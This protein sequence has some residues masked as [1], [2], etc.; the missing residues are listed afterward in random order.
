MTEATETQNA[1]KSKT[2]YEEVTMEDGRKVQFAG[3]LGEKGARRQLKEAIFDSDG[4]WI[5]SQFDFRN[6]KT[7]TFA[8]PS[9][10]VKI[11]SGGATGGRFLLQQL[12]AHGSLQKIGDETAGVTSI[13]DMVLAVE[14]TIDLLNKGEWGAEREG[15]G[16][17]AG[18]SILMKALVEHTGKT[19]DAIKTFLK[20]KT[21]AQKDAM[22]NDKRLK[23]IVDRLEAEEAAKA[24]HV[25]T[26]ALFGELDGAAA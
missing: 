7:L 13:D 21:K 6:G 9:A 8:A 4:N 20:G 10:D 2:F 16:G 25:N 17:M 1:T 22:K 19:V 5:G 3:K 14:E 24:A 26:E 15:G 18:T 12:A 11:V 23:P